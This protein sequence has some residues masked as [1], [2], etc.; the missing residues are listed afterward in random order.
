METSDWDL[1][2]SGPADADHTVLML[3]GAMAT[4]AFFQ[5]L[6]DTP[7]LAEAPVR[8]VAATL[9]GFAGTTPPEDV[10]IE[11]YARVACELARAVK[12]DVVLG[13]SLGAN[14]AIEMV[15]SG[16]FHGPW[17]CS[18]LRFRALTS[19][20]FRGCSIKSARCLGTC[21]SGRCS[22]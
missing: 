19:Q 16:S 4:T 2:Q 21:R 5:D 22:G 1:S 13:H 11:T 15:A 8:L 7:R 9:P 3:A 18:H 6:M 20:R 10:E 12:A 14:V 17:S